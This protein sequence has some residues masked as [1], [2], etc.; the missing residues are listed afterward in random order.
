MNMVKKNIVFTSWFFLLSAIFIVHFTITFF[1]N[2]PET[3]IKQMYFSQINNYMNPLFK[4]N[5]RLFAPNPISSN[6]HLWTR[7]EIINEQGE[8]SFT[9]WV[10]VSEP[11]ITAVHK[12]RFTPMRLISAT[13]SSVIGQVVN[14]YNRDPEE[15]KK[16]INISKSDLNKLP[17]DLLIL[18]RIAC[19]ALKK[20]YPDAK[21][22]NVENRIVI[23]SFKEFTGIND[24][25]SKK[26]KKEGKEGNVLYLDIPTLPYTK[27]VSF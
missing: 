9:D 26:E 13:N 21:F 7:G 12:N 15:Y 10:N 19:D 27:V 25:E 16:D 8:K 24:E 6:Q 23:S 22:V 18:H 1:Y 14:K 5:W 11:L 2:A 4:Q 3:P 20:S 17:S